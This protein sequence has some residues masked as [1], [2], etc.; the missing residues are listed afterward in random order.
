MDLAESWVRRVTVRAA[1]RACACTA[2]VRISYLKGVNV[3]CVHGG[4]IGEFLWL[5]FVR[6]AAHCLPACLPALWSFTKVFLVI[7]FFPILIFAPLS[8]S[9]SAVSYSHCHCWAWDFI[10]SFNKWPYRL[11][12]DLFE[13]SRSIHRHMQ[14]PES[15]HGPKWFSPVF[16]WGSR[17]SSILVNFSYI[18]RSCGAS[19]TLVKCGRRV[20][21]S[22]GCGFLFCIFSP[23][24][25][26]NVIVTLWLPVCWLS[27]KNEWRR[28]SKGYQEMSGK[29]K[30]WSRLPENGSSV[31][32]GH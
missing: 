31:T 1:Y 32:S 18:S 26:K 22:A 21:V 25:Q 17:L 11:I 14:M 5:S 3:S 30:T 4:R 24:R 6:S 2:D 23:C 19:L 9:L 20:N 15:S 7:S 8:S 13:C 29:G 12:L 16:L 28:S 10:R 27:K